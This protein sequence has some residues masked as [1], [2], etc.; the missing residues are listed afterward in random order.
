MPPKSPDPDL[1]AI[2]TIP[3]LAMDAVQAANSGHPGTPMAPAPVV[4]HAT[5]S[6]HQ[7][8]D[9]DAMN[10]LDERRLGELGALEDEVR[11]HA[12]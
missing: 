4:Y 12:T 6:G 10:M 8:V 3:T 2:N 7:G 11:R 5:Y 9:H 1:L